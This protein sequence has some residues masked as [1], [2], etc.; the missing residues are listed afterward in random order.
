MHRPFA[1]SPRRRA[2]ARQAGLTAAS[3]IIVGAIACGAAIGAAVVFGRAATTAIG[4]WIAAACDG[5]ATLAP[6]GLARA[7]CELAAPIVG[8]AALAAG[9][10]HIVQTRALW[11]PRRKIADAPA[12]EPHRVR[13]TALDQLAAIVI[14][15]TA[16]GWLWWMTPRLAALVELGPVEAVTAGG[17]LIASLL[18][19]LAVAW[20][21]VGTV[22]ALVRHGELAH[23]LAMSSAE[24][25][26]DDRLAA[27][28]P[29]WRGHRAALARAPSL[30]DVVAGAALVILGD[31]TAIAIAWDP[32][33]QPVPLRVATGRA[34]SA[35]QLLGLARRYRIAVHRDVALAAALGDGEG[36]VSERDWGRL[37]KLVA[38]TR[39]AG[40]SI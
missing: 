30:G 34:A 38:A 13:R 33:R 5:R 24:K 32:V 19:A 4:G 12:I 31:D 29:R 8:L 7:V 14:G 9:L 3:P 25:R 27:A 18:A 40:A 11:L 6:A 23:A 21:F 37:A 1:P 15:A 20:S 16:F 35:T 26:E 10:A 36:P 28:D 22:D 17:A 39:G 2:L